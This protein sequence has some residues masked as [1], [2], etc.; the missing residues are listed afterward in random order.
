[1][2]DPTEITDTAISTQA[3]D[4]V[5]R[6]A[7]G[8]MDVAEID[9]FKAWL[10]TSAAHARAFEQRRSLWQDLA[11][12][13]ELFT[14]PMPSVAP[15]R[16]GIRRITG[17]RRRIAVAASAVAASLF[18]IMFAPDVM[19]RIEADHST[20]AQV[21]QYRLSDGST[22]WLDAGSAISVDYSPK[23]RKVA[24]LRG[25]AFFTVQHGENRPFRV[26]ALQGMVEDIGTSFEVRRDEGH[27]D[28]AVT[29]GAVRVTGDRQPGG[30]VVLRAGE[31]VT[32]D[33][34]GRMLSQS[35]LAATTVATWRRNELLIDRK[36]LA[37]VIGEIA[38][39]RR[40]PTWVW[41]DLSAYRSVNGAFRVSDADTALRDL[42]AAQG[43]T[44]TWLPGDIAIIRRV[45]P[46]S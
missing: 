10:A 31:R 33:A 9:R 34:T 22:V 36:P 13:P 40:G 46:L 8:E 32:Y 23:E 4:W 27:V 26:A 16:R 5:L 20:S 38:R 11:D 35:R 18:A 21:A 24:L 2:I 15:R 45:D 12:R 29:D 37:A 19:V 42:A 3:R 17:K 39:Y 41:A 7:S 30:G 14:R 6:L 25:N 1:M 44:I 43:L 28:V